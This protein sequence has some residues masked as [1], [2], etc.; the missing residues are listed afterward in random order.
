MAWVAFHPANVCQNIK[1]G[2]IILSTA[3]QGWICLHTQGLWV[4]WVGWMSAHWTWNK[5]EARLKSGAQVFRSTRTS[6]TVPV[7]IPIATVVSY[8][9]FCSLI[10]CTLSM[11]VVKLGS[12]TG[13]CHQGSFLWTLPKSSLHFLFSLFSRLNLG[14]LLYI[15]GLLPQPCIDGHIFPSL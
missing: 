10:Q 1:G 15:Q 12:L 11:K 2:R 6:T 4:Q 8:Q 14:L 7:W 9:D 13:W 5:L 3:E